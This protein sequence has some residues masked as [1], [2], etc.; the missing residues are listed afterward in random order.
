LES[1]QA[2]TPQTLA[3][4]IPDPPKFGNPIFTLFLSDDREIDIYYDGHVEDAMI[5]SA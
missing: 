2:T 1:T 4:L 3:S 5:W